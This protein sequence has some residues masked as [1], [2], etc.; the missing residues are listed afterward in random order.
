LEN[1]ELDILSLMIEAKIVRD[2]LSN[3]NLPKEIFSY[4]NNEVIENHTAG[5]LIKLHNVV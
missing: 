3:A 4:Q 5:P 1:S 2:V